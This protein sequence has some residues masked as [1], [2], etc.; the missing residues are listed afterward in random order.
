MLCAISITFSGKD[1]SENL[2]NLEVVLQKL[3]EHNLR[4]KSFK[5]KF[6]Q[7]SVEYLGQVVSAEGIQTSQQKVEE[8]Q[9]LAPPKDQRSLR[10]L[11]GNVKHY[12]KFIPFL[13]DLSAPLNIQAIKKSCWSTDCDESLNKIKEALSSAEVLTHFDLKV[14]LG[15][16]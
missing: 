12:G 11:L 16:A 10:S 13:A 4:I 3:S 2:N 15:L 1:E 7:K 5:C 14:Q 6:M 9:S 8:I